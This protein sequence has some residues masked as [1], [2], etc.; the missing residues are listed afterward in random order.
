MESPYPAYLKY[1]SK[2]TKVL[3]K[4]DK[5]DI[6]MKQGQ[7]SLYLLDPGVSCNKQFVKTRGTNSAEHFKIVLI[8]LKIWLYIY[9]HIYKQDINN[10]NGHKSAISSQILMSFGH[11][12]VLAL[13]A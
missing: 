11:H 4:A 5:R 9:I 8:V 13:P 7:S 12:T 6:S 10:Q 1:I 2:R 3:Q